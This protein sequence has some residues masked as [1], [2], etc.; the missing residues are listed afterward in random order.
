MLYAGGKQMGQHCMVPEVPGR[1][2]A[3]LE[4]QD[5]YLRWVIDS[6][7]DVAVIFWSGYQDQGAGHH[8]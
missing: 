5:S 3:Y 8:F 4:V 1:Q 2:P 6:L 7:V